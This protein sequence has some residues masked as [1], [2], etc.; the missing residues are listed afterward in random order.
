M[1]KIN[2][3]STFALISLFWL[4]A[5]FADDEVDCTDSASTYCLSRFEYNYFQ[6][7]DKELNERYKQYMSSL[8]P[9][10]KNHKQL[11]IE[12]QRAWLVYRDK[13]CQFEKIDGGAN[14]IGSATCMATVTQQR[15]DELKDQ[16]GIH[17][18]AH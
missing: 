3:S 12:S 8:T 13:L 14:G 9:N 2:L 6:K 7:A 1:S 11:L 4:V 18:D 10:Q 5:A 17:D 15:L 16:L